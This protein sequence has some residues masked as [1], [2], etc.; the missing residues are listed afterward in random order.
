MQLNPKKIVG[1]LGRRYG[2][3]KFQKIRK[4]YYDS[5]RISKDLIGTV[6]V[7]LKLK[8]PWS[9]DKDVDKKLYHD[10][11]E[12]VTKTGVICMLDGAIYHGGLTDRL[13]GIL[14]AYRE[15]K[16]K[17][18][19]FYIL[20]N[21]SFN[22]SDYLLPTTFDWRISEEEISRSRKN[23]R[24]VVID[25]MTPR[26][27][28]WRMR[29]ALLSPPRQ[30]HFYTNADS[31]IGEYAELFPK[32]FRPSNRLQAAIDMH[33]EKLGENYWVFTTR[34]LTLLGDFND[35][36]GIVLPDEDKEELMKKVANEI[37][38]LSKGRPE[39]TGIMVT[40]DSRSFLEYI[41]KR[42]VDLYVVEGKIRHIDLDKDASP[43]D[44]D[45]S[46][47]KTFV[48]QLLI[49]GADK[50]VRMRTEGMY[51]SGFARFAAEVGKAEFIDHIF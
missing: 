14:T 23:S 6:A 40:S 20:W 32:L 13:R 29:A 38:L 5:I 12:K 35:W 50:V 42:N 49:M 28:L 33:K 19:P 47:M 26:Q 36:S 25:D 4:V 2:G 41:K 34:F 21:D 45:D 44:L 9:L 8:A 16:K 18:L 10:R 51:A 7:F 22:L 46:T 27:S 17:G 30:L 48:D 3:H 39:G 15:S 24:V 11:E 43:E 1:S 37:E 31:A